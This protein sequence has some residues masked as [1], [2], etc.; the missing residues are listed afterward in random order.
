MIP[1]QVK[2]WLQE[3]GFGEIIFRQSVGGG[4]IN[5]GQRLKTSRGTS[6]FLKTNPG[7]P[8]DMFVREAEGLYALHAASGPRVP[9]PFL[10]GEEFILMED[11]S[12]AAPNKNYWVDFGRKMADLHHVVSYQF[13]FE[14]ANY[15]GSTPQPNHFSKD[16]YSFYAEHRLL[17][18][19]RL[20]RRKGLLS[21]KDEEGVEAV[22]LRL[23]E[24]VPPQP[25]SLLHG[26]LWS[27]NA[28]SDE[29]GRP[30]IIDPAVYYG[31]AEADLAM[32]DLF[33]T[34]PAAFYQAYVELRPLEK[35]YRDRFDIYNLYHLLNHVNLFGSG[36]LHQ[37][38][39]VLRK[40]L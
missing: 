14:H 40:Y 37:V 2:E 29:K 39:N 25:A 17:Y 16:G 1:A 21:R 36:Y 28:I 9:R 13:G 10:W 11:L 4:C 26:D 22:A 31:W 12:P 34:F 27:G 24:L 15:I 38:H 7:A 5:N 30:A 32:T 8:A 3:H 33:G 23:P 35:G 19:V 20:A 6:F 18:Q